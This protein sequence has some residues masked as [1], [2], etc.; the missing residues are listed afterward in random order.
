MYN[1]ARTGVFGIVLISIYI[2]NLGV[3]APEPLSPLPHQFLY[4]HQFEED[5]CGVHML[6]DRVLCSCSSFGGMCSARAV[7]P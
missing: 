1:A 3:G 2:D 6:G 7:V 5:L 4:L